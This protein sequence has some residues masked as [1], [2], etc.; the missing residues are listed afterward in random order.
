LPKTGPFDGLVLEPAQTG[1]KMEADIT[2][3]PQ[4]SGELKIGDMGFAITKLRPAGRAKFD[5]AIVDVVAEG[6]L[7]EKGQKIKII[8]IQGNKVV[9]RKIED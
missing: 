5:N 6:D 7:I 8:Q 3:P 4:K 2:A 9:V 1:P